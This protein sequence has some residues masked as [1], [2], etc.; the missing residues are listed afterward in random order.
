M[1]VY[2]VLDCGDDTALEQTGSDMFGGSKKK[3]AVQ[4]KAK[5]QKPVRGIMGRTGG[6]P[7]NPAAGSGGGPAKP[8]DGPVKRNLA[9]ETVTIG[10]AA[11]IYG[12][13]TGKG[14][15]AI[16]GR[17]EGSVDLPDN[18][19]NIEANGFMDGGIRARSVNIRGK[20]Q[21]DIDA[22][23]KVTIFATGA[24]IGTI[25]APRIQIEDGGKFKGR[26]DMGLSKPATTPEPKKASS[27][28][29]AP[30]ASSG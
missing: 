12:D 17:V 28:A 24:V 4:T 7:S 11:A 13:I 21:G 15:L 16:C 22:R 19:A 8:A 20:V 23:S 25:M 9:E 29:P 6:A 10:S 2:N 5:Q 27:P 18:N 3:A 1:T 30:T 26:I 14:D